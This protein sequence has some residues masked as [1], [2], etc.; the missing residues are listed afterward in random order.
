MTIP[1]PTCITNPSSTHCTTRQF[2][3]QLPALDLTAY[4]HAPEEH[5]LPREI[6]PKGPIGL[7]PQRQMKPLCR[8]NVTIR[9]QRRNHTRPS[10]PAI[11]PQSHRHQHEHDD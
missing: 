10:L 7:V 9:Q 5:E 4:P 2:E 3:L 6:I 11:K 1:S 8:L